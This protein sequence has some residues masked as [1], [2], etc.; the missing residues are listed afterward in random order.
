MEKRK[1]DI[2][3]SIFCNAYNHERYIKDAIESMISQI[4]DFKFEILVHDD[5]SSDKTP[6]I[7]QDYE[8]KYPDLI[9]AIYQKENKYSKGI[10]IGRNYQYPRARGKYIAICEGDDYWIDSYKLQKQVDLLESHLDVDM[11]AHAAIKVD[12]ESKEILQYIAPYDEET[13]ASMGDVIMGE[14]GF[15]ATNS[16]LYRRT[17]LDNFPEFRLY[18]NLDYT[19]QMHGALR[20]GIIYIP[21]VMS[22]YRW[23][24]I[25]SWTSK[26]KKDS[27]L[28]KEF[29]NKK[30]KMLEILDKETNGKHSSVIETRR[31]LNV[32][33][34]LY[35]E[36]KYLKAFSIKNKKA[37]KY[38]KLNNVCKLLIKI[39]FP[40][41]DGI[42]AKRNLKKKE[43]E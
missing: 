3:V 22:A 29:L 42:T 18:M 4:T 30:N 11:C 12:A 27:I 31:N 41:L 10:S 40:C 19:L 33:Y 5:A 1:N 32:F 13:I 16:L 37:L 7:I 24:S 2:M 38:L 17:L 15:F 35:G 14:G 6:L 25:G 39:I 26:Q 34:Y 20:G 43:N 36:K 8:T 23:L 28:R 21:D 9:K